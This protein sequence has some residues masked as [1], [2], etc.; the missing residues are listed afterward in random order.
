M[1]RVLDI[2]FSCKFDFKNLLLL[3]VHEERMRLMRLKWLGTNLLI[4]PRQ[5]SVSAVIM[6][7]DTNMRV[8]TTSTRSAAIIALKDNR[9]HH[10][11]GNKPTTFILFIVVISRVL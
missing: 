3:L 10:S 5:A 8:L 6:R 2:F 9:S 4:E 7:C 1:A 11:V